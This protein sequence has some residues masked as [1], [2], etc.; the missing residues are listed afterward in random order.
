MSDYLLEVYGISKVFPN[1]KALDYIQLQIKLYKVHAPCGENSAGESTQI[2]ITAGVFPPTEDK[3]LFQ[4]KKISPQ[5]SKEAQDIDVGFVLLEL[6]LCPHLTAA[7]NIFIVISATVISS[8]SMSDSVGSII[9]STLV[10][11]D[12]FVYWKHYV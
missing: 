5:N 10:M 6:S 3:L 11:M 2:N 1:T 8:T 12:V 7:K 4:S 9:D